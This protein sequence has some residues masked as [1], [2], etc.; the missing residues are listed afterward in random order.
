MSE[1][2]GHRD[3]GSRPV[4][5]G[6]K[7]HSLVEFALSHGKHRNSIYYWLEKGM[8]YD[9]IDTMWSS[10]TSPNEVERKTETRNVERTQ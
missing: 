9:E 10:Q 6:K 2:K 1:F 4:I 7:Y 5:N 3:Y 8:T